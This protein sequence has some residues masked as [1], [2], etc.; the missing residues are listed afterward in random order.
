MTLE[1]RTTQSMLAAMQNYSRSI[2]LAVS[3]RQTHNES[4]WTAL[5]CLY[6]LAVDSV[7][8]ILNEV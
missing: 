7:F 8:Q 6:P 2:C 3:V 4:V 5:H 1:I